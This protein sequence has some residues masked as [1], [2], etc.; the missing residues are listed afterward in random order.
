MPVKGYKSIS[1]R[2]ELYE[3]LTR[4]MEEMRFVSL[5]DVIAFLLSSSKPQT[6]AS[7]YELGYLKDRVTELEERVAKLESLLQQQQQAPAVKAQKP[8][9]GIREMIAERK[10]ER[11]RDLN[12]KNPERFI[13]RARAE[14]VVVLEGVKDTGLVDPDFYE[15]FKRKLEELTTTDDRE[16]AEKLGADGLR[17][18]NFMR[19]NGL[20]YYDVEGKWKF[21]P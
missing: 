17:L 9:R 1:V 6:P 10:F 11:L 2:A 12:V 5:N 16:L 13:E 15:D 4:L 8:R 18:F 20:I 14:G 3:E 19:E 7:T 21:V